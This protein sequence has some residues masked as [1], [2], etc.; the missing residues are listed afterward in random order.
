M[1][2]LVHGTECKL[3]VRSCVSRELSP[4]KPR[5][6]VEGH[7]HTQLHVWNIIGVCGTCQGLLASSYSHPACSVPQ[8]VKTVTRSLV[9]VAREGCIL[10][11]HSWNFCSY[12]H[13]KNIF[14][15][16]TSVNLSHIQT[17][18]WALKDVHVRSMYW[19]VSFTYHLQGYRHVHNTLQN[20]F[21]HTHTHTQSL[22]E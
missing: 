5:V 19:F 17:I 11:E 21:C 15:A 16:H 14:N 12:V 1:I 22:L 13:M 7:M 10:G 8:P 3:P 9:Y 18:S 4:H 20:V 2:P 6:G